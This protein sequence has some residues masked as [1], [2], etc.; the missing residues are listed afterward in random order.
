MAGRPGEKIVGAEREGSNPLRGYIGSVVPPPRRPLVLVKVLL[1]LAT[2]AVA[3][4]RKGGCLLFR[5]QTFQ[6]PQL[7]VLT[8]ARGF[9]RVTES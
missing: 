5:S 9:L 7:A 1:G 2:Y 8:S 3:C 4:T 6:G